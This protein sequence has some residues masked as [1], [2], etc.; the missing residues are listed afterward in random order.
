[1]AEA[2]FA[3]YEQAH[4]NFRVAFVHADVL[5]RLGPP[6]VYNHLLFGGWSRR[7][8]IAAIRSQVA[9]GSSSADDMRAAMRLF[10]RIGATF[11]SSA[12]CRTMVGQGCGPGS[13]RRDEGTRPMP[14]Y[15]TVDAE[16]GSG[17]TIR[18]GLAEEGPTVL[19]FFEDQPEAP[20]AFSLPKPPPPEPPA[21]APKKGKGKKGK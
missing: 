7:E 5:N 15:L 2:D 13:W 1:M 18:I 17:I 3:R 19:G 21:E 14:T 10:D 9:D 6:S 11:T 8:T 4:R 20:P 12:E 16:D